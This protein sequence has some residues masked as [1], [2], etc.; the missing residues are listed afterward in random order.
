MAAESTPRGTYWLHAIHPVQAALTNPARRIR[1]LLLTADA[2]AALVKLVPL[3]WSVVPEQV[4]KAHLSS[5]LPEDAV[6]QGAAALVEPLAEPD[7]DA[8]IERNQGPVLVLDQVTDPRNVGAILR[9]AAAFGAACVIMQD[10]HAPPETGA[11]ARAASGA[12]ELVPVLREVNLA[13]ALEALKKAGFWVMGLDGDGAQ[14]LAA[15]APQDRRVALVLGAEGDGMRRLTRE[16]CDEI[17]R[18]P[19]S[20]DVES[21]NVSAAASVALYEFG[22]NK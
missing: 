5:F 2:H 17:C 12:L 19:I 16:A 18:L 1:R 15:A 7:W 20:P 13:R 22:R 8:A 10:R 4:D 6:H 11:L 9:S 14:T 3:P 21:L